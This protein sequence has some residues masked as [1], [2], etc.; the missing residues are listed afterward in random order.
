MAR[1]TIKTSTILV[2]DKKGLR[3]YPS[4]AEM[5]ARDRERLEKSLTG[6]MAA[7]VLIADP[8]GRDEILKTL[9]GEASALNDGIPGLVR[10]GTREPETALV[11]GPVWLQ[12][13]AVRLLLAFGVPLL[14]GAGFWALL[15]FHK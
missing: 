10:R 3:V 11:S 7:T 1:T 5:P 14:F 15:A 2:S 8:R 4:R 13:R 12:S 6:G 9:R